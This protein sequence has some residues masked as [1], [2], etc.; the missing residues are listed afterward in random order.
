MGEKP[1]VRAMLN[2]LQNQTRRKMHRR[3]VCFILIF[4]IFGVMA[5]CGNGNDSGDK[6]VVSREGDTKQSDSLGVVGA[7]NSPTILDNAAVSPSGNEPASLSRAGVD[8][9]D[10]A[11]LFSD[12]EQA[13]ELSRPRSFGSSVTGVETVISPFGPFPSDSDSGS[14]SVILSPE[15]LPSEEPETPRSPFGP[16]PTP[17]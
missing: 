4:V 15:A 11:R 13:A 12:G 5:G 3:D 9:S 2:H 17:Q 10:K 6:I 7:T 8:A 16:F 14:A 1:S